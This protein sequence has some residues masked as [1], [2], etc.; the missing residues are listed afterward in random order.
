MKAGLV[1]QG[2]FIAIRNY[3][4]KPCLK[5]YDENRI[6]KVKAT[7]E[8]P[9]DRFYQENENMLAHQQFDF[10]FDISQGIR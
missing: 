1:C 2:D 7:Y 6:E 3:P 5:R 4:L 8:E 10:T 9:V